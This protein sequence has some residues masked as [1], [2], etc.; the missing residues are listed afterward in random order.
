MPAVSSAG[1]LIA[2]AGQRNAGA[3]YNELVNGLLNGQPGEIDTR[4]SQ[5]AP[6]TC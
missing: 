2:F 3:A 6:L 5:P 1:Q 4:R